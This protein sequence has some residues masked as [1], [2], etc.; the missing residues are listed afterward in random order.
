MANSDVEKLKTDLQQCEA[1]LDE[2]K[3]MH[4][5]LLDLIGKAEAINLGET[6][7]KSTKD[8]LVERREQLAKDIENYQ[9]ML[10]EAN[11]L[12]KSWERSESEMKNIVPSKNFTDNANAFDGTIDVSLNSVDKANVPPKDKGGR[13]PFENLGTEGGPV[14][15]LPIEFDFGL[16]KQHKMG[17]WEVAAEEEEFFSFTF[18]WQDEMY[19]DENKDAIPDIESK[20]DN[21]RIKAT[22]IVILYDDRTSRIV[23][24]DVEPGFEHQWG[25]GRQRFMAKKTL[26][27]K[28]DTARFRAIIKQWSD[29]HEY[30]LGKYTVELLRQVKNQSVETKELVQFITQQSAAEIKQVQEKTELEKK[31][32]AL[33]AER[34]SLQTQLDQLKADIAK[35]EAEIEAQKLKEAELAKDLAKA[36]EQAAANKGAGGDTDST[37]V[38]RQIN[39]QKKID[40]LNAKLAAEQK[41]REDKEKELEDVNKKAEDALETIKQL[42]ADRD[43]LKEK[44]D[45]LEKNINELINLV[46]RH[47]DANEALSNQNKTL[48]NDLAAAKDDNKALEDE[49]AALATEKDNATKD[50]ETAKKTIT[51]TTTELTNLKVEHKK[52]T[53]EIVKVKKEKDAVTAT[54]A[55]RNEQ[56]TDA[57]KAAREAI[58]ILKPIAD[59]DLDSI[60]KVEAPAQ[61]P[62]PV[63]EPPQQ[64]LVQ[65]APPPVDDEPEETTVTKTTDETT[66]IQAEHVK[67]TTETTTIEATK[68]TETT[69]T[70]TT[71]DPK[72]PE[73]IQAERVAEPEVVED[74]P[75]KSS[76]P[77]STVEEVDDGEGEEVIQAVRSETP[78]FFPPKEGS[79]TQ[80]VQSRKSS[81]ASQKKPPLSPHIK[82]APKNQTM[83]KFDLSMGIKKPKKEKKPSG[84]SKFINMCT[85]DK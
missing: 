18:K 21:I 51:T 54:L 67:T 62:A 50:L 41:A 12:K 33:T 44:I 55:K 23:S 53:E 39:W 30:E 59:I 13:V 45:E 35:L 84:F 56:L 61:A 26:S 28:C 25:Y 15:E 37:Q 76:V 42:A 81:S 49:K 60:E 79:D 63:Q 64:A 1:E 83:N 68:T 34:D 69:V 32:A 82:S 75:Q 16:L 24:F 31:V 73:V 20:L 85:G 40:D 38:D 29:Q 78:K 10:E 48:A 27:E 5:E 7:G 6:D 11:D 77:Q 47:S 22:S 57:V 65:S 8:M 70:T 66:V 14:N 71:E 9:H 58:K 4:Q 2:M 17:G 3:K 74:Q 19:I 36:Q 43:Q 72:E 52:T 80:S 46:Q